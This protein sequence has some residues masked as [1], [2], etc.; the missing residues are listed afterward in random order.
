MNARDNIG[1]TALIMTA[2]EGHTEAVEAL[3]SKG[4]DINAKDNL[5]NTALMYA[6]REGHA[7]IAQL[8][9]DAGAV[10]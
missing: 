3:L 6:T 10:Q 8:L 7:E 1:N 5:G 2:H 9:R 4:A